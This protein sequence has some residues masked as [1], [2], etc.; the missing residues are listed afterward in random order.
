ML[1]AIPVEFGPHDGDRWM[2]AA[3]LL[4]FSASLVVGIAAFKNGREATRIAAE[5]SN[6]DE[7]YR[8]RQAKQARREERYAAAS[9]MAR[10]FWALDTYL[11]SSGSPTRTEAK[12]LASTLKR[13]AIVELE[14]LHPREDPVAIVEWFI[15]AWAILEFHDSPSQYDEQRRNEIRG[16]AVG[17]VRLWKNRK[18][19]A[20]GFP[21]VKAKRS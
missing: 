19:S 10:A 4:S 1:D 7:A 5:A 14:L 20:V 12:A 16:E 21:A 2:I 13:E 15:L 18:I 11:R 3:T 8:R 17:T 9:A 6:R